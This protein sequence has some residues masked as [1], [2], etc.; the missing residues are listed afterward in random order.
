MIDSVTRDAFH[1]EWD[2]CKKR[3]GEEPPPFHPL[4]TPD[5]CGMMENVL[6]A[7]GAGL[8]DNMGPN[9]YDVTT[10]DPYQILNAPDD[11]NTLFFQDKRVQ[12]KLNVPKEDPNEWL[13]CIPGAGRRRRRRQLKEKEEDLLP[14][15]LLL[16]DDKPISMAPYIAE[17]LD[18]A[19]IQV[20]IYN[21]DRDLSTCAQGS[22]RMLN[23]MDW[24]GQND[25]LDLHSY[26][27]AIW[28]VDDY[29]AGWS[30]NVKNLDFLIIYNSGHLVRS[31]GWRMSPAEIHAYYRSLSLSV[32]GPLQ[33]TQAGV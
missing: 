25:W 10:W 9:T 5:E 21:G 12:E 17:L 4:T 8:F 13:G 2:H 31:K 11:T 29:P 3:T 19:E 18:E 23:G 7:A 6:K 20:L 26:K 28:L 22:E 33:C 1:K 27:R 30:K 15:Q 14:G 16:K 32:I 24:S